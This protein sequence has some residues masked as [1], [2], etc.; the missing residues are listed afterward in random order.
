MKRVRSIGESE[1][2]AEFLACELGSPRFG[3]AV[4]T[5]LEED[6]AGAAIMATPDLASDADNA[7]RRHLLGRLRGYG[8]DWGLFRCFPQDVRWERVLVSADDLL[9]AEYINYDY[10]VELSGGSRTPADAA[11]RIRRGVEV[12][13]QSNNGF[14]NAV[15]ALRSG[16][17][18]RNLILVSHDGTRLVV[19]E[20]HVRLTAFALAPDLVPP[21]LEAILGRSKGLVRWPLY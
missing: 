20:G 2:V 8:A 18:L 7:Y 9:R 17:V 5:Q 14:W 15:A 4:R 3:A 11:R 1:M 13:G 16:A 12:F 21:R 10:W 19:L 6:G